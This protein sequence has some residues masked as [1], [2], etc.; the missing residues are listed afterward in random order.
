[1]LC[2][3]CNQQPI[4]CKQ[5]AA[6]MNDKRSNGSQNGQCDGDTVQIRRTYVKHLHFHGNSVTLKVS[7]EMLVFFFDN[8]IKS[9]PIALW[10][11]VLKMLMLI[12][13]VF[14]VCFCKFSLNH[15]PE[16]TFNE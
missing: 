14:F 4:R 6:N 5:H 2:V 13:L 10:N 11:D 9:M 16:M 8:E 12:Q 15:R 7:N 1:M 3:E